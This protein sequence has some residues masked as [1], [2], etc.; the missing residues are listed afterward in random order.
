M[1]ALLIDQMTLPATEVFSPFALTDV[2]CAFAGDE[3]Q[4]LIHFWQL[5]R[6]FILGMKDARVPDLTNGLQAVTGQGYRP[7]LRNAGGLG[8]ISDSG[9]LNVSLIV[10]NQKLSIDAAYETMVTW[11]AQTW[12]DL[13]ITVGEIPT[14]YCPGKFDLAVQGKKI[15]GIAQRRVKNG[16]AIMLYL[17]VNGNQTE[18]GVLVR[19]FYEQ[20][21]ADTK[22]LYPAV[23]PASMTTLSQ[24]LAQPISITE[25]KQQLLATI[26]FHDQSQNIGIFFETPDYKQRLRNMASRNQIIKEHLHA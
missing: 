2:L 8:V 5:E 19:S 3:S 25:A 23:D 10:P 18:R 15:A 24:L 12:P 17:S 13:A 9:I 16:V 7:I 26:D 21:Q 20:S 11:L 14:S 4:N 1:K 22:Q 6:T